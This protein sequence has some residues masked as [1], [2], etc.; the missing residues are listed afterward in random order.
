MSVSSIFYSDLV[1]Y[2][3][4]ICPWAVI[5]A[6]MWNQNEAMS[7]APGRDERQQARVKRMNDEG[8]KQTKNIR[9]EMK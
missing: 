6:V 8:E 2:E 1:H 7:A 3:T 4:I 5:R 9:G